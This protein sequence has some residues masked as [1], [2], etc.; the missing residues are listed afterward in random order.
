MNAIPDGPDALATCRVDPGIIFVSLELSKSTG[1][2]TS[3]APASDK[4]SR[5]TIVGGDVDSLFACLA[6]LRTKALE[7]QGK[8]YPLVVI[9]EAG[10][11]G[12]WI[13]RALSRESWITSHVVDAAS[14]AVSRRHRRA[15][16][17]RIDGEM[18]IRTLMAYVRGEPRFCS[19][20]RV[21]TPQEED[22]RRIG[23]ERKALVAERTLHVVRVKGLLFCQGIR[24]YEP[25]HGRELPGNIRAQVC[26]ELDRLEL[27]LDQVS[28]RLG[29][30]GCAR[31]WFSLRGYGCVTNRTRC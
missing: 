21:P 9:K 17:D 3:L 14:I 11:D 30:R 10:L 8:L 28:R 25:L 16:T 15:K 23:R 24:E 22:R 27:L 6:Q 4:M 5:R 12:F 1:L 31:L 20:V 2:V 7:R 19:M 18:L 13:H 26:R 29:I